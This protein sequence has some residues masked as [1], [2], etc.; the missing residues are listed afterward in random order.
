MSV[1]AAVIDAGSL[2]GASRSLDMPLAT[3]SRKLSDL[4][5]HLKTQLVK[6]SSRQLALTDAGRD[7]LDASRRI[8]EQVDEAERAASGEYAKARGEL[9]V[10]APIAFGH[11]HVAPVVAA[12]L[13]QY[14]DIDVRLALSDRVVNL[15]EEHIDIGV[16]IG[17]LPDS[18]LVARQLGTIRRVTCASPAYL[19]TFG[20]PATPRALAS[21]RCVTFDGSLSA[22]SWSYPG[23]RASQRIV[24]RSR[25]IVNTAD[26]ALA[27]AAAGLGLTR[28]LSYQA[29]DALR[30]GRLVRVLQGFEPAPVPVSLVYAG[31]GRLPMKNRAFIDFATARLRERL[32][33]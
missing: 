21:H 9:A 20:E 11:L 4:E 2:S 5:S 31:Q 29:A 26:A 17:E 19:A 27:A 18:G 30:D 10:A 32:T 14:P 23:E 25:M 1:F 16:R 8:L 12:F 7:Y 22:K 15:L 13:E 24:I 28:V 33:G 3:V 6:R